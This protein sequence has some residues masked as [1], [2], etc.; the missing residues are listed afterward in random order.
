MCDICLVSIMQNFPESPD[1]A[2]YIRRSPIIPVAVAGVPRARV[3]KPARQWWSW[4]PETTGELFSS[5]LGNGLRDWDELGGALSWFQRPDSTKPRS[6]DKGSVFM[7]FPWAILS[8]S[9]R[10]GPFFQKIA[11]FCESNM[12]KWRM[13][14]WNLKAFHVIEEIKTHQCEVISGLSVN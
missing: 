1:M 4:D 6:L 13:I 12:D 3:H 7:I 2:F 10:N 5:Q 11:L 14:F 9:K 8:T